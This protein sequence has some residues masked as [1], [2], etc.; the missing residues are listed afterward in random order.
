[1]AEA[2]KECYNPQPDWPV[3]QATN[4]SFWRRLDC[5][6]Q[7]HKM[8]P[9]AAFA[10]AAAYLTISLAEG[11]RAADLLGQKVS[12]IPPVEHRAGNEEIRQKIPLTPLKASNQIRPVL[13]AALLVALSVGLYLLLRSAH[14]LAF[15]KKGA[16]KDKE[17]DEAEWDMVEDVQTGGGRSK[18]EGGKGSGAG[19]RGPRT[20]AEGSLAGTTRRPSIKYPPADDPVTLGPE[21]V[22]SRIRKMEQVLQWIHEGDDD[23]GH[24]LDST[25]EA[26]PHRL[27]QAY[28]LRQKNKNADFEPS[29]PADRISKF[30]ELVERIEE[31]LDQYYGDSG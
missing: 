11:A 8:I 19:R 13:G 22:D 7:D 29:V 21:K 6:P 31:M 5:I 4:G 2:V 27:R 20:D 17:L 16:E 25:G 12:Y 26:L 1:M 23:S 24:G 30:R 28:G 14:G 9:A 3:H 15:F 10:A 18:D